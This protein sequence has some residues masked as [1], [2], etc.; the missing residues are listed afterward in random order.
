MATPIILRLSGAASVHLRG[1]PTEDTE[2][3]SLPGR[4][5]LPLGTSSRGPMS[6]VLDGVRHPA[7]STVLGDLLRPLCARDRVARDLLH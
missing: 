3:G 6:L 5:V 7:A 2:W 4:V 1:D